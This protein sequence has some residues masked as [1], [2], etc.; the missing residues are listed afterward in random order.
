[1]CI[2]ENLTLKLTEIISKVTPGIQKLSEVYEN[3]IKT[4]NMIKTVV[5][6]T[7]YYYYFLMNF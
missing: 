4:I 6:F 1:M 3:K 5:I 2:K 7:F